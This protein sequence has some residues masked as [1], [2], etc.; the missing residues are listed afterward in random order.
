MGS[1]FLAAPHFPFKFLFY[2]MQGITFIGMAGSGKSGVGRI[3]AQLLNWRFVDLD[4][5]ILETQGINH[6]DYMNQNGE[7]A[8]TAL[9][10]KLSIEL[11]L[12]NTIF[13]P[14]GSVIYWN[15]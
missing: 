9:E 5:L 1:G 10:E 11:D 13:S 15:D 14:P 7:A 3:V 12:Q 6:D 4:K 8:L 2:N